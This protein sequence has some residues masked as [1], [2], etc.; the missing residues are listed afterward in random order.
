MVMKGGITGDDL[1]EVNKV[2]LQGGKHDTKLV[3][4]R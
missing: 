1:E 3:W 4:H 2:Y